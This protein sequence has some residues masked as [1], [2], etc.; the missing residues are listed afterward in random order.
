MNGDAATRRIRSLSD[1]EYSLFYI[2]ACWQMLCE[3]ENRLKDYSISRQ[4]DKNEFS[5][6]GRRLNHCNASKRV[7]DVF[8]A[9]Y[10]RSFLFH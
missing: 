5:G 8:V 6:T 7:L 10:T 9:S 3:I 4:L 1:S 2:H